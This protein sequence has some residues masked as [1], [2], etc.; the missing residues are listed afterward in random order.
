MQALAIPRPT[1]SP[2]RWFAGGF[3]AVACLGAL[4]SGWAPVTVSIATV[5]LFA[6]PHNWM[7]ARYVLGRLPARTGSLFPFFAVSVVGVVGLT[8][9]FA[10]IP[11]YLR[12]T[13]TTVGAESLYA[14]WNTAFLLW[15]ATLVFMRSRTNPR[16]EAGWVW[17]LSF[18]LVAGVWLEP[19]A[20]SFALVY[21]HPLMALWLLDRELRRSHRDWLPAYRCG[22]LVMPVLLVALVAKLHA[23]PNL[24]GDDPLTVAIA[25]H[26]GDWFLSGV[27]SHLLVSLHTFLEMVHYGVWIILIPLVGYRF[28]AWELDMIP[29]ARRG[30]AWRSAVVGLLLFGLLLVAVLWSCFLLDYGATRSV[31][32][33]VALLHVLAEVPFLLRMI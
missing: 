3:V 28:K 24:P 5:F 12:G 2:A 11:N 1:S 13:S 25:G 8:A 32:F 27:S 15:L 22:L 4:L 7:E 18:L 9:G 19:F 14:A 17:P 26:A 30:G 31:Y 33:T 29:V 16:F 23:A 21:L 20:F 6:G 10:V